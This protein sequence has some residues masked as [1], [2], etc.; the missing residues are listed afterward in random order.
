MWACSF[1]PG[2]SSLSV[3]FSHKI[4]TLET[5]MLP[6]RDAAWL[7]P[8]A[9]NRAEHQPQSIWERRGTN[10]PRKLDLAAG[11]RGVR[12]K[13][14]TSMWTPRYL[15]HNVLIQPSDIQHVRQFLEEVSEIIEKHNDVH[16]IFSA[17]LDENA[18]FWDYQIGD[19]E[20]ELGPEQLIVLME[21]FGAL[22]VFHEDEVPEHVG[23]LAELILDAL[24][25]QM[26]EDS[27]AEL[28][29]HAVTKINNRKMYTEVVQRL[30][31]LMMK[32]LP[33]NDPITKSDAFEELL[34]GRDTCIRRVYRLKKGSGNDVC[35]VATSLFECAAKTDRMYEWLEDKGYQLSHHGDPEGIPTWVKEPDE[36]VVS[37]IRK[38]LSY[39]LG[40]GSSVV[41]APSV[42]SS[43]PV[44]ENRHSPPGSGSSSSQE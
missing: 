3:R 11:D 5:S 22:D 15:L 28:D 25:T 13:M 4:R 32:S 42:E 34:D 23:I 40:T 24:Q 12:Y 27:F 38:C 30:R 33:V 26:G 16:E 1:Q 2:L 8:Q 35:G 44:L 7:V 20:L 6:F 19:E 36:V 41:Q 37:L 17:V 39:A 9:S 43:D 21:L 18:E 14:L 31:G 29:H 10:G